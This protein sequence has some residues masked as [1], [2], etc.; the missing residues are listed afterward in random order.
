MMTEQPQRA[1]S[2]ILERNGRYLLVRR[3]NPPSADMYAFPGG[4]AEPGETPAETALRE[5]AEETGIEARNPVLFEAYDLPGKGPEE[6]H[7]LLSVFTVEADP[8]SVAVACDDAAGLGWF[9][10]EEIFDLPIPESVRDCVEKL[11]TGGH[12][13]NPGFVTATASDLRGS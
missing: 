11:A 8:D 10:R 1:S 7:F 5:L 13:G 2:A 6:R 3:A 4:R 12:G 9:T